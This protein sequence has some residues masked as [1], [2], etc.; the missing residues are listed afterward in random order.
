[1]K[2]FLIPLLLVLSLLVSACGDS[3]RARQAKFYAF[4]TEIDVSLYGVDAVTA[5]KTVEALEQ[6]FNNVNDTWHA[7]QP[8][9]LTRINEAI[10]AGESV[11]IKPEVAAVIE[12]AALYA[13]DSQHL[14]NPAAGKL[15][16]LWGYHQDN[17]FESRPPPAQDKI[18]SWLAAAPTMDDI[19]IKD[20]VL[21]SDNRMVKLGF[22]GFAKGTAVDAAI[23]AL[24][25]QG[26]ENAIIN[27]GGDLRAIG[28]HGDRPWRI[29][30]R[31]PR[32]EGGMIAS[33]AIQGDESVFT[34]GDYERFFTYEGTRYP[35]ILD[36]RTGQPARDNIS[37]TVIHTQAA[38]A[39]AAA[40]AL[41]VAGEDWPQIAASLGIDHVMLMRAD[42]QIEMTAAMAEQVRLSDPEQTPLIRQVP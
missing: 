6:A 25:Q 32:Q 26:I 27:I 20:G 9:T 7:W 16:E 40:T 13:R 3:E 14:F 11:E 35:H 39:D 1:M 5:D 17:W 41:V 23:A 8:S 31:H 21:S 24:K 37:V 33:V 18:D 38:R 30:I 4:G 42:G 2:R 19:Q 36:P 28:R 10:A 29:G 22:G 34:S 12:E 15:F